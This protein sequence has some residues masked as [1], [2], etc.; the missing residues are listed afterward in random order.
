MAV[1]GA[2]GT[3]AA[4]FFGAATDARRAERV[5]GADSLARKGRM[6]SAG[7]KRPVL[8][9]CTCTWCY[10][11]VTMSLTY[12]ATQQ[13]RDARYSRRVSCYT[14]ATVDAPVLTSCIA[15]PGSMMTGGCY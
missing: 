10:G 2:R 1:P 7:T 4:F 12:G 3:G 15:L 14:A 11:S 8:T 5:F 6:V 9:I 13:L